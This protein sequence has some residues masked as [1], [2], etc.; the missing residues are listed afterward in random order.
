MKYMIEKLPISDSGTEMPATSV[1]RHDPR[2]RKITSTTSST[3]STSSNC[4][5][6]TDE[7]IP[8]VRSASTVTWTSAGNWAS[9]AG[10]SAL[11]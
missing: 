4:T 7:R 10:R 1:A 9:S 11:I 5:S 3:D 2:N 6:E 8:S